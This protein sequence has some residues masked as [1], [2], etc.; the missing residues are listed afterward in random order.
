MLTCYVYLDDYG[1]RVVCSLDKLLELV[2]CRCAEP[3]CDSLYDVRYRR[4]G[5]V[6]IIFGTC[7]NGHTFEWVSS[8]LIFN[9]SQQKLYKDN[10]RFASSIVLSGNNLVKIQLFCQF[11]GI[12]TISKSTFHAYQQNIICPAIHRFYIMKQVNSL[13]AINT[14]LHMCMYMWCTGGYF[15]G[16]SWKEVGSCKGWTL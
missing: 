2:K 4:C 11:F 5:C 7:E 13:N 9:Q 10:L 8:D 15:R 1:N 14:D 6:I 3:W 16:M 12:Q